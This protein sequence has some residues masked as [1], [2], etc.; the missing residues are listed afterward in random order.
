MR[1]LLIII[2]ISMLAGV[3]ACSEDSAESIIEPTEPT[4]EELEAS[5]IANCHI[6]QEALEA[7]MEDNG[8]CRPEDVC[9][10][11]NRV[12]LT[13]IDYLPDGQFLENPFTG[14]RTEPVDTVA[15]EPGQTGFYSAHE[16]GTPGL[17][18]VNGFGET[19]VI[20]EL[21]NREELE[22]KVIENCFIVREAVMRFALLN[23]GVYPY[24]IGVDMNLEGDTVVGLLPGGVLLENPVTLCHT[25]PVD[26]WACTR[27]Q[28]GYYPIYVG[29]SLVGFVITGVGVEVDVKIFTAHSDPGC[30]F[31][32]IYDE[33]LYCSGD[34][35]D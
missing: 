23:G 14:E 2:M 8:G 22:Q 35:C 4:I 29:V 18:Y 10:D 27:G 24:S 30:T 19:H 1:N 25:E 28:V 3:C 32:S 6:L 33:L 17:Y 31:I 26:I 16:W 34:C 20:V 12:G 5:V 15:T 9:G 21:S 13:L 7:F 11:T